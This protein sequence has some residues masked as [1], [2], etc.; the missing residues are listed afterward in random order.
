MKKA[1][2]IIKEGDRQ[3]KVAIDFLNGKKVVS[4]KIEEGKEKIKK[5]K[6]IKF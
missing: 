2:E 1:K 4:D 6:K 5:L 3:F